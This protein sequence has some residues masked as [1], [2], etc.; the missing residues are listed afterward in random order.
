[1]TMEVR[2][3]VIIQCVDNGPLIVRGDHVVRDAKGTIV[4]AGKYTALCRC[5]RSKHLPVCDG[6]HAA[7]P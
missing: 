6:S 7:P 4:E 5:T 3:V 2:P 1:M